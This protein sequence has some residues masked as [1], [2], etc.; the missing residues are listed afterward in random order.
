MLG[1]LAD[2][3]RTLLFIAG[4]VVFIGAAAHALGWLLLRQRTAR[5]VWRFWNVVGAA[6]LLL[7][8]AAIGYGWLGLGLHTGA[9]SL[10]TGLG[11]L[12]A[13]AGLWML[14]PV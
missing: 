4:L 12:L 2:M 7:G 9:G 14:V 13:S 11:V 8:V 1:P 5:W 3:G 10:V 6:L